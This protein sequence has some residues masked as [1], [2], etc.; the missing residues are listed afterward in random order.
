MF[1]LPTPSRSLPTPHPSNYK[2]FLF[3]SLLKANSLTTKQIKQ[4]KKKTRNTHT[5][6]LP[7][8]HKIRNYNI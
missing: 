2:P 4:K 6:P 3:I 5:N 7:E 8:K 1:P